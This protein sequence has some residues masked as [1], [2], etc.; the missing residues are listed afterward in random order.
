M[1]TEGSLQSY[2]WIFSCG[3]IGMSVML[4]REQLYFHL[5]VFN[6]GQLSA[7]SITRYNQ[8]LL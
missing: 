5:V 6:F 1:D 7:E 2:M 3:G 4:F 8:E